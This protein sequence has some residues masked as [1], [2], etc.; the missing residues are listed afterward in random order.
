[1]DFIGED[2]AC[3]VLGDNIF[4]GSGFTKM[5]KEAVHTAEEDK[6]ATVFGYWVNDCECYGVAK[7]DK[8]D[9]IKDTIISAERGNDDVRIPKAK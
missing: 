9:F 8:E 1:M 7:F 6:K 3:L 5:F 2:S 4:Q